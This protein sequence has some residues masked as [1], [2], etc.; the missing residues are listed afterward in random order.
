MATS[1]PPAVRVALSSDDAEALTC[2]YELLCRVAHR[3]RGEPVP[4]DGPPDDAQEDAAGA[5]P[6]AEEEAA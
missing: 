6:A 1:A 2:A 5:E 3:A 4:G